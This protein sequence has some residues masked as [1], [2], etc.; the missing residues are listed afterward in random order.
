VKCSTNGTVTFPDNPREAFKIYIERG[1]FAIPV[2]FKSKKAVGAEWQHQRPTLEDAGRLFPWGKKRSI[3]LLNGL[4]PDVPVDVDL[5]WPEAVKVGPVFLPDTGMV[6]GHKSKERSHWYYLTDDPPSKSLKFKDPVLEKAGDK[7]KA[8]IV[9]LRSKGSQTVAPPSLHEGTGEPIVWH[10]FTE[11]A[12]VDST[13]LIR[14]VSDIAVASLLGRY[15]PKHGSLHDARNALAGGLLRGGIDPAR[16]ERLLYGVLVV[17]GSTDAADVRNSV[18]TTAERL[19]EER[20][21]QGWPSLAGL[22][23]ENGKLIV[24][25]V[26][27]WLGI[28]KGRGSGGGGAGD[29]RVSAAT[30]M[31][32]LVQQGGVGLFHSAEPKTYA[33]LTSNGH[34]ETWPLK[35]KGFRTWLAHQFFEQT[36]TCPAGEAVANAILALEGNAL[37]KCPECEVHVRVAGL[38]G[39]VY[40]DLADEQWRAVKVTASGWQIVSA[41]PRPVPP[42]G[43]R[44]RAGFGQDVVGADNPVAHRPQP[45]RASQTAPRQSGPDHCRQQ[46]VADRLRQPLAHLRGP[47]RRPVPAV[48]RRW[49][50]LPGTVH[51]RG[52]EDLRGLPP[53]AVHLH[54]RPRYPR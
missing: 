33:I 36:G 16:A 9:E 22:L 35:S 46:F 15:W 14:R 8:C 30:A 13:E 40:L 34:R 10:Q 50:G 43:P 38:D 54:R 51:R 27:K 42:T 20:E 37:F 23:G 45:R 53:A 44:R 12:R 17:A 49:H 19:E 24:A 39:A 28:E 1:M 6:A 7:D 41:P 48:H 4:S 32:Q 21:I 26:R 3:G 18:R 11:A 31:V 52:R 29:D 2:Y 47:Q 5:D 25:R